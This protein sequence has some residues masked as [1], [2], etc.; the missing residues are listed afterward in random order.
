ML[1][2]EISLPEVEE[3]QKLVQEGLEK[4]VLNYDEIAAGLDE[5]ELRRRDARARE[6]APHETAK[7][8]HGPYAKAAHPS[9]IQRSMQWHPCTP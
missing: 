6:R 9:V 5:V 4:G 2:V 1:T 7:R 8:G 3:L